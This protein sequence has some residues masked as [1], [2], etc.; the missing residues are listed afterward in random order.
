MRACGLPAISG[1]RCLGQ[2]RKALSGSEVARGVRGDLCCDA[3]ANSVNLSR[4]ESH[5]EIARIPFKDI[6]AGP[7]LFSRRFHYTPA[8]RALVQE[9]EPE[10]NMVNGLMVYY[11]RNVRYK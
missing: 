10:P 3:E 8:D 9:I 7:Q 5:G 1:C 6:S 11:N 2:V 4:P